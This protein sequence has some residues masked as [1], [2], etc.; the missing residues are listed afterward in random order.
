MLPPL[1]V[2][3]EYTEDLVKSGARRVLDLGCGPGRHSL[4]LASKGFDV[5]ALDVSETALSYLA[6]QTM[7]TGTNKIVLVKHEMS[8]LPFVD[9]YFDAVVSTNVIHHGT[10]LE[11]E[12]TISEIFRVLRRK[13]TALITTISDGD[14]KFGKGTV[15]E[16]RTFICNEGDEDGITHH[17]FMKT[18]LESSLKEFEITLLEEELIPV[19]NGNRA[20]FIVQV[21]KP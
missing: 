2:A 16:E 18:E 13:G 20:H 4:Y 6:D 19:E 14:Y 3:V 5:I 10:V 15:L 12:K 21:R 11:I 8:S 1:P 17:F 9:G 7:K